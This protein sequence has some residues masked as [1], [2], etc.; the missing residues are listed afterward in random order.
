MQEMQIQEHLR[1]SAIFIEVLA[2]L[3]TQG[4]TF[5]SDKFISIQY[6]AST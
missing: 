1:K 5:R 6:N 4:Y 2:L 3:I